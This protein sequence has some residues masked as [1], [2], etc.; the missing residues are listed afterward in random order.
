MYD[1]RARGSTKARIPWILMCFSKCQTYPYLILQIVHLAVV[2]RMPRSFQS[3]N[4]RFISFI[5]CL[6]SMPIVSA[7]SESAESEPALPSFLRK[8]KGTLPLIQTPKVQNRMKLN[9][10]FR[11]SLSDCAYLSPPF[12]ARSPFCVVESMEHSSYPSMSSL[13]W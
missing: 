6:L 11:H 2:V 4:L 8:Y 7:S 12:E 1:L 3:F 9:W 10:I 13:K 5:F